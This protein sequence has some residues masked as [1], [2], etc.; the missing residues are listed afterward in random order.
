MWTRLIYILHK[1]LT[2]S[3]PTPS[4]QSFIIFSFNSHYFIILTVNT[5]TYIWVMHALALGH[6]FRHSCIRKVRTVWTIFSY[7][8]ES[9][10]IWGRDFLKLKHQGFATPFFFFFEISICYLIDKLFS[11]SINV[12]IIILV[13]LTIFT[14]LKLL[15]SLL[16]TVFLNFQNFQ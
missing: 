6:W 5:L 2:L 13:K 16:G 9:D 8:K 14:L 12:I 3:I 11:I 10:P 4:F 1:Q 7:L 15:F